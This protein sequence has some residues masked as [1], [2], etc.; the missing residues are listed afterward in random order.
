MTWSIRP[1]EALTEP[2]VDA[3]LAIHRSL[4]AGVDEERFRRDLAAKDEVVLVRSPEGAVVGYTTLEVKAGV[5]FSG[6]TGMAR[7]AWGSSA[8][9]VGWLTAALRWH[10]R[11]GPLDWLLLAGGARTYR[12]L[13]LFFTEHW[14]RPDVPTPPEV[15]ARIDALALDRWGTAYDA[16][17]V[18]LGEPP[19]R[20]E[21][22]VPRPHDP[23]DR[24][25]REANP[26]WARGDELV[27]LT[28][29]SRDNLT[30]AGRRILRAATP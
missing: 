24:F 28:R 30:S 17:V 15:S 8:L 7:E 19:L 22:D 4:Y 11:L 26:G 27:C 18:A 20:P 10:D 21:L 23:A 16:G 9:Q 5:L 2:E 14:P 1:R 25:F 3:M 13:P 6:D 29:V 12:Y